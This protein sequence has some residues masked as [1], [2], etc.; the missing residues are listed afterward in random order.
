MVNQKQIINVLRTIEDPTIKEG[1][2]G[3]INVYDLGLIHEILINKPP[4]RINSPFCHDPI[5]FYINH[6]FKQIKTLL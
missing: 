6:W 4:H 2:K 1:S 3:R 5:A